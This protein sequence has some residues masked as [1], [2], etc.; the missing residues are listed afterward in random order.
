MLAYNQEKSS[1][2]IIFYISG[3][4]GYWPKH[5]KY[6]KMGSKCQIF[7]SLRTTIIIFSDLKRII[8]IV[9]APN[10]L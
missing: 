1:N 2:H 3:L 5:N 10:D 6:L 7:A 4:H 9:I 8:C